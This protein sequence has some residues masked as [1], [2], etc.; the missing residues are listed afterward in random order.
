MHFVFYCYCC[1]GQCPLSNHLK[2][3]E[4]SGNLIMTGELPP[5]MMDIYNDKHLCSDYHCSLM[6]GNY[7]AYFP[8]SQNYSL[9]Q[10]SDAVS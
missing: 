5:C 4:K 6:K 7:F 10:C 9:I 1:E 2:C 8:H 3:P